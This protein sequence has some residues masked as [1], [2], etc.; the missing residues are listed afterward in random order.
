MLANLNFQHVLAR[1]GARGVQALASAT[2]VDSGL[3]SRSWDYAI[4]GTRNSFTIF[5]FNRDVEN[6]FKVALRLQ[7][8][9]GTGTGGFVPGRDYINPAIRPVF[10][11]I[12]ADIR[13]AV[14]SIR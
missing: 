8:G 3:S 13:K 9:Y 2:P 4:E 12:E 7:Y 1:S 10:D 6:G 5:W 14:T 11:Q